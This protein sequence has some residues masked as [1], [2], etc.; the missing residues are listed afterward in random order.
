MTTGTGTTP[1]R[2]APARPTCV[3]WTVAARVAWRTLSRNPA[4]DSSDCVFALVSAQARAR[5]PRD[6]ASAKRCAIARDGSSPLSR[7]RT[8]ANAPAASAS[9]TI[10][11]RIGPTGKRLRRRRRAGC[12][13]RTA[14]GP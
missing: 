5:S 3:R 10:T 9:S 4:S 7:R 13:Q 12:S 1:P 2:G 6:H 14:P 11:A 8:N